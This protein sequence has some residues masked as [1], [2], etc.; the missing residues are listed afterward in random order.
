MP[1]LTLLEKVEL[2]AIPAAVAGATLLPSLSLRTGTWLTAAALLLLLQ[3]LCRDAWL[4]L[5]ARRAIEQAPP[6]YA[7]CMCVESAVG[8]TGVLIGAGLTAFAFGP[9]LRLP[10]PWLTVG[11][12]TVLAGGFLLKDFVFEWSPW[13]LYRERDHATLH[14][15]WK[16]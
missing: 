6:R 8:M 7:Q 14:F 11:I 4:W 12:A 5:A 15:R 2:T 3:G 1:H 10:Q 13:R 9:E 16:R